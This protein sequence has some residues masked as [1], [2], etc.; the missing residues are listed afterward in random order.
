MAESRLTCY[1]RG[2]LEAFMAVDS[3]IPPYKGRFRALLLFGPPGSGKGTIGK[4]LSCASGHVHLSSGDIFR[5]LASES[6]AGQLFNAYASK[7]NLVPDDLTIAICHKYI[8][9]LI[10]TNRFFPTKQLLML[11]GIPRTMT[12]A[13]LMDKH[14]DVLKLLLLE[15]PNTQSLIARLKNRALIEKRKDDFDETVL[16]VRMEVYEKDTAKLLH[17]YPKNKIVRI[18]ADQ[19]PIEVLRDV[20]TALSDTL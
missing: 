18:N 3:L 8:E 12:Q 11:D 6:P 7:G 19:R 20:I 17:H 9:G 15:M 14:L 5:G 13:E 1:K 10:D 16:R 4:A 2:F